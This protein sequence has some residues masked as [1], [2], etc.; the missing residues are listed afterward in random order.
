MIMQNFTN[1]YW[2][3][4]VAAF[5][6]VSIHC[7]SDTTKIKDIYTAEKMY[8]KAGKIQRNILINPDIASP[9]EYEKAEKAYRAIIDKFNKKSEAL[10][11]IKGIVQRSWLGIA[12]L[13]KLQ[14][15]YENAIDTYKE[16]I[17]ES[18]SDRELCAVA[19]FSMATALEK[20]KRSD[21]AIRVYQRVVADYPPV[22]SDTL[23]PNLNILQTPIY[24]ARLYQ[25]REQRDL[26]EQQYEEA[27]NYYEQVIDQWPNSPIALAAQNQMAVSYGDQGEWKK[28]AEILNE[29]MYNY[30]EV[31]E[32][33]N[34]MLTLGNIYQLQLRQ[35]DKALD[36][37]EQMLQRYP[38]SENLGK[39]YL[40]MGGIY[41]TQKKYDVARSEFRYILDN[42]HDDRNSCLQ[43]QL[44]V[45]RSYEMENN[46]NKAINEYQWVVENYPRSLQ[47]LNIPIYIADHYR[48]LQQS[49]LAQNAYE[50]AIKKYRQVIQQYPET[51]LATLALDYRAIC[52]MRTE[53]WQEASDALQLLVKMKLPPQN[54]VNAYL[55]LGS[56]YEEKLKEEQKAIDA[57]STLLQ[58][59]PQIPIAQTIS[60]KTS[61]LQQ[62]LTEYQQT[63]EP[64]AE[65]EIVSTNQVSSSSIEIVWEQNQE[66]DFD[67]YKLIRSES[68]GVDSSDAIITQLFDQRQ[69]Q[70]LD[71]DLAEGNTYYYRLYT[72]DK[73]GLSSSSR[74]V[75]VAMQAK[76][77]LAN[78]TLQAHCNNWSSV[79]LNWAQCDEAEF[80]SYKIYRSN[81][82]GVSL[83]SQSVKTVF[84]RETTQL[85]DNDLKENITYYYKVY[86]YNSRG[87]K[88][89][90]NEVAITTAANTPPESVILDKPITIDNSSIELSWSQNNDPDFS[91]Y[92]IYRSERSPV[93]LNN[94]PVHISSNKSMNYFKDTRLASGKIYYYKVVVYDK[95]GLFT[96]SNEISIKL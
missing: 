19:Q 91:M 59:Y 51:M 4:I 31:P 41:L 89:P 92:R 44:A 34:I 70:Y 85:E 39:V 15:K 65:S 9:E 33:F 32:I 5:M 86:V 74:E 25:Q 82:P 2:I 46:W 73:G 48:N 95:G 8:F 37:Y 29:I 6:V 90:S 11:E 28:S 93:S 63:N 27:R 30:H 55:T 67:S 76:K 69:L 47:A 83:T 88:Q 18:P 68:S 21:E 53:K 36:I 77:F 40:A 38:Q 22:L 54:E 96:E 49:D 94:A 61:E 58:K 17:R 78:I 35:P 80:D 23:L 84:D 87:A 10:R 52:Y 71:T 26:A 12:E 79:T 3:L 13:Y 66:D 57:Y 16:I 64:P 45:A 62:K 20:L 60:L 72:F 7:S 75:S 50:N 14:K 42:Y 24:I 43:A 81:S 56:I 1:R